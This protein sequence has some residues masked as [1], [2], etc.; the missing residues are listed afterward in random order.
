MIAQNARV[1]IVHSQFL[2]LDN[3]VSDFIAHAADVAAFHRVNLVP[4]R[5]LLVAPIDDVT[6]RSLTFDEC[7]IRGRVQYNPTD[8]LGNRRSADS[9]AP[10]A[11]GSLKILALPFWVE[12]EAES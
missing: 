10:L 5:I 3:L 2:F 12:L 8:A 7:V 9:T 6:L 11:A 4:Q 1:R